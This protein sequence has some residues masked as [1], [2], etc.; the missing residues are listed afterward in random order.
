APIVGLQPI[1]D[2]LPAPPAQAGSPAAGTHV[3]VPPAGVGTKTKGPEA[4][5]CEKVRRVSSTLT[6]TPHPRLL[7]LTAAPSSSDDLETR[8]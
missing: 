8:E 7:G 5:G 6:L 3:Q 4:G 2:A 1:A